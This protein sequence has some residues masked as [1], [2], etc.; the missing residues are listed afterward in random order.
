[1]FSKFTE[2]LEEYKWQRLETTWKKGMQKG[3]LPAIAVTGLYSAVDMVTQMACGSAFSSHFF[4]LIFDLGP[5]GL[6]VSGGNGH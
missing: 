6:L 5:S 1:M 2:H 3:F 4:H